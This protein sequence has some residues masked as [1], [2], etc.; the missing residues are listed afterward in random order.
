MGSLTKSLGKG[1]MSDMKDCSESQKL[2]S[3]LER[4]SRKIILVS[5]VWLPGEKHKQNKAREEQ[6]ANR[7]HSM[8]DG[9]LRSD[10]W[11]SLFLLFVLLDPV[12]KD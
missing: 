11:E 2:L 3:E 10:Q 7:K 8:C 1:K 6:M 12:Q 9:F 4:P 5:L